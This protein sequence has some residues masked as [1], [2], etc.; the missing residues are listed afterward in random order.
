MLITQFVWHPPFQ[1]EVLRQNFLLGLLAAWKRDLGI[2]GILLSVRNKKTKVE[3]AT[4][5]SG[6]QEFRAQKDVAEHILKNM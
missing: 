6:F 3:N 4:K 5:V 2:S 1:I